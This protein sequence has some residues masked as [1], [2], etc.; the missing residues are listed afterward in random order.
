MSGLES[1]RP[2]RLLRAQR[3]VL[4]WPPGP[5]PHRAGHS[6]LGRVVRP[7]APARR[8]V[9]L[10]SAARPTPATAMVD[11]FGDHRVA[12]VTRSGAL[13]RC[14]SDPGADPNVVAAGGPPA[15]A[16]SIAGTNAAMS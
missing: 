1:A 14:G 4:T 15:K 2:A 13:L 10:A 3:P 16:S 6:R 12:A 9:R 11:G 5:T 8:A 7:R